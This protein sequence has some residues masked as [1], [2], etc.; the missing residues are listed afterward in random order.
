MERR[1]SRKELD[2]MF[3][4]EISS[5]ITNFKNIGTLLERSFENK[6]R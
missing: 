3:Y 4:N 6:N 5:F 2:D 1:T